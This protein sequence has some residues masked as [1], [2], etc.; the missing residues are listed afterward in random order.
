MNALRSNFVRAARKG[1]ADGFALKGG[2]ATRGALETMYDGPRP[3]F[4]SAPN[5]CRYHGVNGTYQPMRKQGRA[6]LWISALFP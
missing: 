3:D 1:R 2:D 5:H 4:R 6:L